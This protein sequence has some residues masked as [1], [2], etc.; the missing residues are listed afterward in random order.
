[1]ATIDDDRWMAHAIKLAERGLYT[2]DP[3]PRV[4]CVIVRDGVLLAAGFHARAG[5]PHAERNALNQL[6]TTQ[7]RGACAY[8]TLEPCSHTG[9][10][11]PCA[12]A[13][14]AAGISRVV[15]AMTDPNPKVAGSGIKRLHGAGIE[16][17]EGVQQAPARALNPGF[18]QRFSQGRPKITLKLAM[19]LDGRTAM[20]SGE[21]LWITGSAARE[22]VQR[23]RAR[24][25][26]VITG[27]GTFEADD[28]SLTVRPE[29]WQQSSYNSHTAEE[30]RT[31]SDAAVSQNTS[32][33]ADAYW[34]R[35]PLRVLLDSQGR[36][37]IKRKFFCSPGQ[38][39]VVTT[40]DACCQRFQAAGIDAI[41][42]PQAR[43]LSQTTTEPNT[44]KPATPTP[45]RIDLQALVR[46][47]ARR[48]C[49]ELLVEAGATLAAAFIEARLVDELVVYQA[50]VL[51][52]Q[53]ARP[54]VA[55]NIA[56]MANKQA[57]ELIDER[58]IG[59]DHRFIY[60]LAPTL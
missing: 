46:E 50:P 58:R 12:D 42:L 57:L 56:T 5:E 43:S 44:A 59:R 36:A 16:V 52:G 33:V 55:L 4:G 20:A 31:A 18:I 8:V 21:S 10:T 60:R 54:L 41:A 53:T 32:A 28:P 9:R 48:D 45:G 30:T 26:A 35:Q 49:N 11:G 39:L 7:T 1:M 6:D 38:P 24:S 47:L 13:L 25:S 19:S 37:D 15:V 2:T 22:D 3:N 29:S 51:L 17:V 27:M 34:V 14:I 40:S 23:L